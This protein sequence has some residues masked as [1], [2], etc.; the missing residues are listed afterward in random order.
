VNIYELVVKRSRTRVTST[1][2]SHQFNMLQIF[3]RFDQYTK[4]TEREGKRNTRTGDKH[5]AKEID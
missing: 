2:F 4:D 5:T 3:G 1:Q